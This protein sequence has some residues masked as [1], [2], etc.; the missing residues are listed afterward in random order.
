MQSWIGSRLGLC[1]QTL[2]RELKGDL[3]IELSLAEDVKVGL[4]SGAV[5]SAPA[6]CN[7]ALANG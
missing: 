3:M 7:L 4:Q 2:S 5:L 6:W 1:A